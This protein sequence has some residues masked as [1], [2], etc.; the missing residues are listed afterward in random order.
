MFELLNEVPRGVAT[1]AIYFAGLRISERFRY[2]DWRHWLPLRP[3]DPTFPES[4]DAAGQLIE[5]LEARAGKPL[6]QLTDAEVRPLWDEAHRVMDARR[7]RE[8]PPD[9][10]LGA[11]VLADLERRYGEGYIH[12]FA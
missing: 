12:A 8:I 3:G 6:A 10:A 7:H 11:R 9:P 1:E 2:P 5:E 4:V